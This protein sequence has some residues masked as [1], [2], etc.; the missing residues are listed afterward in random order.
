M[1]L[2]SAA[3]TKLHASVCARVTSMS[4]RTRVTSRY[5]LDKKG[6]VT[7]LAETE[8]SQLFGAVGPRPATDPG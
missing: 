8:V 4:L 5:A 3:R 2:T 6:K 7:P 1:S